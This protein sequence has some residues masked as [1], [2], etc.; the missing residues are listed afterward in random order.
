[1]LLQLVYDDMMHWRFGDNGAYQFW[2]SP[3]DLVRG[4]WA[5][6]HVTFECH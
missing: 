6:A 2:I 5:A 1:M 3:E 4:N